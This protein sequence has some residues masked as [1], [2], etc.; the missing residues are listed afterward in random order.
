MPP[1]A[2]RFYAIKAD[3]IRTVFFISPWA[4]LCVCVLCFFFFFR[5]VSRNIGVFRHTH[6]NVDEPTMLRRWR[7]EK[8][9]ERKKQTRRSIILIH[10]YIHVH[11][12]QIKYVSHFEFARAATHVHTQVH[13]T[14]KEEK[15]FTVRQRAVIV[16]KQ[17]TIGQTFSGWAH[18][19]WVWCIR[20]R[21]STA[22]AP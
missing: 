19:T 14:H 5:S 9:Y 10:T 1:Q 11:I 7:R 8:K 20:A 21:Q 4:C 12:P 3:S 18:I 15:R 2:T 17:A 22:C 16:G 13:R 6:R